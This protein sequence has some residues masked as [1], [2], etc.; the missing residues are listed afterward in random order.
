MR[1]LRIALSE[2]DKPKT[3]TR[4]SHG[5]SYGFWLINRKKLQYNLKQNHKKAFQ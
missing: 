5:G 2:L 4:Y 3:L 1:F